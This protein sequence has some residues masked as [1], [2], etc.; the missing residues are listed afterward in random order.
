MA[1]AQIAAAPDFAARKLLMRGEDVDA[2]LNPG[3]A[4]NRGT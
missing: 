3:Y 4:L 1:P 2:R